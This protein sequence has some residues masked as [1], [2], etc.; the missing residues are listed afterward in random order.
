MR[1]ISRKPRNSEGTLE[2]RWFVEAQELRDTVSLA[3]GSNAVVAVCRLRIE[4]EKNPAWGVV[5]VSRK[6]GEVF[7][8]QRLP[9][10]PLAG[11]LLIDRGG[12]VVVVLEDGKLICVGK[13][14]G[15][16]LFAR[17][18]RDSPNA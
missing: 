9:Y 16:R 5:A 17:E 6:D 7:W 8:E 18:E 12:Q 2:K 4:G 15:I 10:R 3:M 14:K 11:G 1:S 13:E